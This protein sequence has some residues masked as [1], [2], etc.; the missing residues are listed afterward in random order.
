MTPKSL[1][2]STL[3]SPPINLAHGP[4][5]HMFF[6]TEMDV[7]IDENMRSLVM[8]A[9][10]GGKI[11]ARVLD[12][13]RVTVTGPD[14]RTMTVE[15]NH[16]DHHDQPLGEQYVLSN[17]LY[18]KPGTNRMRF[19]FW[20]VYAPPG[21]NYA[22][23]AVFLVQFVND[24][25]NGDDDE[26]GGQCP[27]EPDCKNRVKVTDAIKGHH[28]P[29]PGAFLTRTVRLNVAKANGKVVM[30]IDQ[31][32]CQPFGIDDWVNVTVRTPSGKEHKVKISENDAWGKPI[33][34]QWVL[35]NVVAFEKGCHEVTCELWNQF[36]PAGPNAG[37]S[38]IWLVSS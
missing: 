11:P 28:M 3:I 33:G 19:E 14:G 15:V 6:S 20:S 35:S 7:E 22:A 38:A 5:N 24:T 18:L 37:S 17:V 8:S 34:E 13:V 21:P 23:T 9:D 32:G 27:G 29:R 1:T 31:T 36:V 4:A 10:P 26:G 2:Q 30:S 16:N 25:G 12:F